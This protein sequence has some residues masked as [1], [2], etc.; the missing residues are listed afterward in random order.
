MAVGKSGP[1]L[2]ATL[3]PDTTSTGYRYECAITE[4]SRPTMTWEVTVAVFLEK[5]LNSD[6]PMWGTS[7]GWFQ[8][9]ASASL[10][11]QC[12]GIYGTPDHP[13]TL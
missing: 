2:Q 12:S 9:S 1:T 10:S 3:L 4:P 13:L 7:G 8:N 5:G 11:P 6:W